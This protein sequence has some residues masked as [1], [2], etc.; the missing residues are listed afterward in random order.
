MQRSLKS[1]QKVS[2]LLPSVLNTFLAQ[3]KGPFEIIRQVSPVDYIVQVGK[4]KRSQK[5]F[6]IN[7]L[8]E[9]IDRADN[10]QLPE[11]SQVRSLVS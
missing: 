4:N 6:H 3:W 2:I 10:N 1:G 8:K 11:V 5:P 7:M 9:W